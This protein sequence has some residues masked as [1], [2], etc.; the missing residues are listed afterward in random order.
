MRHLADHTFPSSKLLSLFPALLH[1]RA[2]GKEDTSGIGPVSVVG[3]VGGFVV[4]FSFLCLIGLILRY[5]NRPTTQNGI[6][7]GYSGGLYQPSA[8]G[9]KSARAAAIAA[10]DGSAP[11]QGVRAG[12]GGT[13]GGNESRANLLENSSPMGYGGNDYPPND[14]GSSSVPGPGGRMAGTH[15]RAPSSGL[16]FPGPPAAA[17]RGFGG[18]QS[19]PGQQGGFSSAGPDGGG[20]RPG[21]VVGGGGGFSGGGG[22]PMGPGGLGSPPANGP[23]AAPANHLRYPRG[24]PPASDATRRS[25]YS[26]AG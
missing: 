9:Y 1:N 26:R 7:V 13:V 3:L 18:Q 22:R 24:P 2:T 4:A 12:G 16:G 14:Q 23:G 21:Q 11:L 20:F 19:H 25:R 6:G 10:A 17:R 8:S 15:G 5:T